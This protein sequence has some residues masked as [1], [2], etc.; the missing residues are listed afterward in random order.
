MVVARALEL[1]EL[2]RLAALLIG[3]RHFFRRHDR[4][5]LGGEEQHR[6]GRYAVDHPV[7]PVAQAGLDAFQIDMGDVF[8]AVFLDVHNRFFHRVG[9]VGIDVVAVD[10]FLLAG[11]HALARMGLHLI[12]ELEPVEG[13]AHRA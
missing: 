6:A 4:I 11:H 2:L 10:H 1:D 3:R 7:W 9:I 13:G 12:P 5:V 8:G